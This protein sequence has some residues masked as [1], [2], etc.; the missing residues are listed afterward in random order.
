MPIQDVKDFLEHYGKKG[1]KWG[2]RNTRTLKK[3]SPTYSVDKEGRITISKG[4][5]L[6]RVFKAGK[7]EDGSTGTNYFSFSKKDNAI[8]TQMMSAGIASRFKF[9]R[10]LA[11][12]KA[13]TMVAT[14]TLK[15]PSRKEAFDI[16]KSTIDE[17]GAQKGVNGIKQFNK[18]FSN[19]KALLWYQEANA[20]IVLDKNTP[21]NKAYFGKLRKSGYNII[22]DELDT[23]RLSELPIVVLD[24]GKSLRPIKISDV[25]G[26]D[27]KKATAFLKA[28]GGKTIRSI[29]ELQTQSA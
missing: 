12:D 21:L 23:G 2:V 13:S 17:V 11:A 25:S 1:M 26:A 7:A 24:G 18:D 16:L 4:H 27:V 6:R 29:K 22:L 19:K 9:L 3:S 10:N 8:Y 28:N 5:Q 20:K 15:S 14:E